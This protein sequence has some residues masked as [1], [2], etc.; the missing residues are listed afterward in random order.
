MSEH[1]AAARRHRMWFGSYKQAGELKKIEVWCFVNDGK[2]EFMTRGDSFKAKRARRN[3]AVICYLGSENGPAVEGT[4]EV[5]TDPSELWRGYRAY[6]KTHRW[7]MC[8]LSLTI[9]RNI[10][11]GRQVL[12][13]VMPAEPN[14]LA[15]M[16]DPEM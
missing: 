15:G 4:A 2:I 8:I 16:T 9:R 1:Q 10:R 11:A 13:R 3:P 7:M 12:I 6:W 14:P 5:L